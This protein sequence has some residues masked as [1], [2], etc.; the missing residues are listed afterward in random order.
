MILL[1]DNYDSFVYNLAQFLGE[2]GAKILVKRNDKIDIKEI[3]KL[4]PESIII[5]S[6]PGRPEDSGICPEV[7]SYFKEKIPILGVCLGHQAIAYAFG[8]KIIRTNKIIHGKASNIFHNGESIFKG[9]KNPFFATRYH[10][11]II[12]KASLPDCLKL[13]AWT[14]NG[15]IMGIRHKK[16]NVEGIQF[17]PESILT[18][19]GKDILSNFINSYNFKQ[20]AYSHKNLPYYKNF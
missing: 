18:N 13:S 14:E 9:I 6:G 4:K 5:S 1:I 20:T 11:L 10:S 12:K 2:L 3:E 7:I 15:L 16:Y 8:G 17:H 19:S